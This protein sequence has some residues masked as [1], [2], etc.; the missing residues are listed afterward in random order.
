MDKLSDE[1]LVFKLLEQCSSY[2]FT[3]ELPDSK[4]TEIVTELKARLAKGRK[5][6]EAMENISEECR[7]N[8]LIDTQKCCS[9]ICKILDNYDKE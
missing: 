1:A 5:A 8:A 2:K 4:I 7:M 6:I 9:K 3:H